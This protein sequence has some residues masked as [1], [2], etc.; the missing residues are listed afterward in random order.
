METV[1]SCGWKG[2]RS[3]LLCETEH[4]IVKPNL[5]THFEV[6]SQ[7]FV[8]FTN[9]FSIMLYTWTINLFGSIAIFNIFYERF[10]LFIYYLIY[11]SMKQMIF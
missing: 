7:K 5:K 6:M 9:K 2:I 8:F 4:K 10:K 11:P 1:R 3:C